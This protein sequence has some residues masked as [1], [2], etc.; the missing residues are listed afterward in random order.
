MMRGG[1]YRCQG[2]RI[3]T[4]ES[5]CKT[6]VGSLH[7]NENGPEQRSG[8]PLNQICLGIHPMARSFLV[9]KRRSPA[10]SKRMLEGSGTV[11]V[12]IGTSTLNALPLLVMEITELR[13]V[14][15]MLPPTSPG[16]VVQFT[17]KLS[18][19]R[20]PLDEGVKLVMVPAKSTTPFSRILIELDEVSKTRLNVSP[21]SPSIV[22]PGVTQMPVVLK[23]VPLATTV[24]VQVPDPH[25]KSILSALAG[26]EA[27]AK[28][29]RIRR[30]ESTRVR[31]IKI[32]PL[33]GYTR[34]LPSA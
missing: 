24:P 9:P 21:L 12:R 2:C 26:D 7:A 18:C 25:E 4:S 8:P 1:G 33:F 3:N 11:L 20:P 15:P 29:A 19:V 31:F 32:L 22:E 16:I 28:T 17:T 5:W 23:F 6:G 13:G 14:V 34:T 27:K 30:T 10:P